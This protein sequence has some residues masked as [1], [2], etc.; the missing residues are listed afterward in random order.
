M[1]TDL[2]VLINSLILNSGSSKNKSQS[3]TLDVGCTSTED[4]NVFEEVT[5]VQEALDSLPTR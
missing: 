2:R 4:P 5:T 1:F 3:P